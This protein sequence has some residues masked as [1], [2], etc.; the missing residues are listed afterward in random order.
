MRSQVSRR[1]DGSS[2]V[3]GSSRK[4]SSGL[5][6]I[7]RPTSSRRCWP[8]ESRLIAVVGLLVQPDQ[9]DHLVDRPRIRVVAGVAGQHLAHRVVGLDRQLLEHDAD[10]GAQP[11]L[12]GAVGRVDPERLDPPAVRW[13][14]PSRISTVVVLPAPLGP[15]SANTSPFCTSKL[16]SR[17]A[18]C[19]AVGLGEMLDGSP[20]ARRPRIQ[21]SA[22]R[23]RA[24]GRRRH[25][26]D[27]TWGRDPA[28]PRP[29]LPR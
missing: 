9:L 4:S 23:Y 10:A 19:L 1:P 21:T 16:T 22:R 2:P 12:R 29:Q 14:N 28:T 27:A 8:P 25:G 26:T 24:D 17:T 6:M 7:P 13:R 5:P 15:S 11:T 3:V 20:Q 18:T